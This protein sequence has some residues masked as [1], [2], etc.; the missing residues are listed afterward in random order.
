MRDEYEQNVDFT[1]V[2]VKDVLISGLVDDDIKKEVLGWTELDNKSV[3]ETVAFIV[4]KEMARDALAQQPMTS[5]TVSSYVSV[6]RRDF[7]NQDISKHKARTKCKECDVEMDKHSWSK[8]QGKMI[9]HSL[10]LVCWKK[11]NPPRKYKQERE[12]VSSVNNFN[13]SLSLDETESLIV[14]SMQISKTVKE[15]NCN[16]TIFIGCIQA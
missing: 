13:T 1:D 4:G 3:Q 6:K 10:C 9:E 16:D 7:K 2:L 15:Q 5:A 12:T 11:A 8:R 14:G